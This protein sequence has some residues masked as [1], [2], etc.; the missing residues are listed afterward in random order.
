M[1]CIPFWCDKGMREVEDSMIVRASEQDCIHVLGLRVFFFFFTRNYICLVFML[2][3]LQ[4][5][6]F[7][8][9]TY[10]LLLLLLRNFCS[11]LTFFFSFFIPTRF[12]RNIIEIYTY[13]FMN[14]SIYTHPVN[15]SIIHT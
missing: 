6:N 7:L 2:F 3:I 4:L 15:N 9:F 8:L 11:L 14:I 1:N 12:S 5:E 13:I 10:I